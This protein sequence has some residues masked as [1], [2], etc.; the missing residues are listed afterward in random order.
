[1]LKMSGACLLDELIAAELAEVRIRA[2][3]AE[4]L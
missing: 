2:D 3:T 4:K 1:M